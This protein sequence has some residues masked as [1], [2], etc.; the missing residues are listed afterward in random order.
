MGVDRAASAETD[1]QASCIRITDS[2]DGSSY[3]V[4]AAFRDDADGEE[5]V[6][7]IVTDLK[8][9]WTATGAVVVAAPMS[10]DVLPGGLT[11]AHEGL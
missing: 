11:P 9:A 3:Y 6:D 10:S 2:N 4:H 1:P 7:L 8:R 5:C